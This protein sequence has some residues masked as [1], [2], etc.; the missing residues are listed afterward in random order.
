MPTQISLPPFRSLRPLPKNPPEGL[1]IQSHLVEASSSFLE[2][3]RP[4]CVLAI[5]APPGTPELPL[6]DGMIMIIGR[7]QIFAM[8]AKATFLA[9][10]SGVCVSGFVTSP[11]SI[12]QNGRANAAIS[13]QCRP[14][15][16]LSPKLPCDCAAQPMGCIGSP[17][18]LCGTP[19][20]A[21]RP[22]DSPLNM[23]FN[24]WPHAT[25]PCFKGIANSRVFTHVCHI[26]TWTL[27]S[28]PRGRG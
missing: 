26:L 6:R 21:P 14:P 25:S 22:E 10:M 17:I 23:D 24:R 7:D 16:T 4:R 2:H 3:C 8:L 12:G 13:C 28:Q 27:V 20:A 18:P 1:S 9:A 5:Q 19:P 15:S 11:I